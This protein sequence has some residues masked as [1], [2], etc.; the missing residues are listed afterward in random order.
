MAGVRLAT[1]NILSGRSPGNPSVDVTAFR[2]AVGSLDADVL[3]LQEVDRAQPRSQLLDLAEIAAEAMGAVELRFVA[4]LAGPPGSW[5]AATGSETPDVPAYG[6]ALLSRVAV[7]DWR[8]VRLPGAPLR[9]PHRSP[10]HRVPRLVRDEPRVAVIARV[11]APDGSLDVVATHLSYLWPS[12]ARQ[13][14]R[15]MASLRERVRPLVLMGDLNLGPRAAARLTG[16]VPLASGQTFPAHAPVV[17]IDHLLADGLSS[18]AGRVVRLPVS[19]HRA[20]VA[21]IERRAARR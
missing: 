8:E 10:G 6:V 20:L 16:L 15:L 13:L 2:A 1:W 14:R 5:R 9:V 7:S 3:A 21:D 11:E 17:Q 19:D 18:G 4:T 12:N